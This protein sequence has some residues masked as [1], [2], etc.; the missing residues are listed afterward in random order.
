[1]SFTAA[2]INFIAILKEKPEI[3][4]KERSYKDP[5]AVIYV[6]FNKK[7]FP[8]PIILKHNFNNYLLK[9]G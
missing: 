1:M 9:C 4:T 2:Y 6:N 3:L 7:K 5:R 8:E